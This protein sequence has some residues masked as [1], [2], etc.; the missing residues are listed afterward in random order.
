MHR[1]RGKRRSYA[2][3]KQV[4]N[5]YRSVVPLCQSSSESRSLTPL[6]YKGVILG[7]ALNMVERLFEEQTPKTTRSDDG[8]AKKKL[9]GIHQPRDTS[10]PKGT[11]YSGEGVEDVSE[12]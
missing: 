12:I 7:V 3:R 1:L 6:T 9:K 5:I 11:G 10:A 4:F 2:G 8:P